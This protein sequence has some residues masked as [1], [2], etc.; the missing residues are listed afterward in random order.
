MT[1]QTFTWPVRAGA[2]AYIQLGDLLEMLFHNRASAFVACDFCLSANHKC[3]TR[4][5]VCGS[6]LPAPDDED[7]RETSAPRRSDARSLVNVLLLVLVPTLLL[8]G[9]FVAWQLV[10][11]DAWIPA[12]EPPVPLAFPAETAEA[13]RAVRDANHRSAGIDEALIPSPESAPLAPGDF[14]GARRPPSASAFAPRADS[15]SARKAAAAPRHGSRIRL[16][17]ATEAMFSHASS[18]STDDVRS[19]TSRE[20]G[21]VV[22]P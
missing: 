11:S 13:S 5:H 17:L 12:E 20:S 6:V 18:A 21:N 9:G 22:R 1:A 15:K 2:V 14:D 3:A 16:P 10:R 19:P 8:C 4:C 7:R